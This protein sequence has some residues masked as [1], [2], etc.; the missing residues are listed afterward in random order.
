MHSFPSF[1]SLP[2]LCSSFK[3]KSVDK[4][5]TLHASSSL[6]VFDVVLVH[7]ESYCYSH[8]SREFFMFLFFCLFGRLFAG[9]RI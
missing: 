4:P 5:N 6:N 3:I 9:K 2:F 1:V 7:E 8:L